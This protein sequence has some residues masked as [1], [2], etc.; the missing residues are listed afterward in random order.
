MNLK[1]YSIPLF[2]RPGGSGYSSADAAQPQRGVC[3]HCS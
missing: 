3:R 1:F 2:H